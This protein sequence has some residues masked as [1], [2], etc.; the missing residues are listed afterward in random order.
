LQ[1]IRVAVRATGLERPAWQSRMIGR[2]RA[3]PGVEVV[4]THEPRLLLPADVYLDPGEGAPGPVES[5]FPRLGCWRFVYGP[6]ARLADAGRREYEAGERGVMARLVSIDPQGQ[7]T[8]LEYGVIKAVPHSL[9]ATR[10]RLQVTMAEWPARALR[11][12]LANPRLQLRGSPVTLDMA[13]AASR[14]PPTDTPPSPSLASILRG[15]ARRL[16]REIREEHWAVGIIPKPVQHVVDAFDPAAIR[17]LAPPAGW[18]I[19]DPLGAVERDGV[20]TMLAEGYTFDDRRGRIVAMDVRLRDCA[21]LSGPREILP[22]P[23]HASYPHLIEH[24]GE[25]YCLPETSALGRVQL[26]R[27]ESFPEKWVADRILLQSFAGADATVCRQGGLWWMFV[28]D[29][30]DQDEAK[31]HIFHAPDLCG[32]WQPHALNPVKCDLRSA[33]PAGPLFGHAGALYRPAQ[34]CSRTYGGAVAVNRVTKLTPTEFEEE[35]V[36][37]LRPAPEYPHGLHTLTGVGSYTL[38]DGKREVRSLRRFAW[39]LRQL[40]RGSA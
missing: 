4:E 38:V 15:Y 8:Q 10:D 27:A 35:T 5:P 16:A 11:R 6:E 25:T 14:R 18:A 12:V 28:G 40:A 26:Y 29:H 17:W 32:P 31:L 7:A 34:D 1:G 36:N 37:V 39:G 20:L 13:T 21:L 24:E 30:A 33:R 19:A 2:L 22:L 3:V 9:Q 23:V